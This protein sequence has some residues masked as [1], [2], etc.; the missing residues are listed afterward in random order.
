MRTLIVLTV[1][2]AGLA[3]LTGCG[4]LWWLAGGWLVALWL[5]AD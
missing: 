4:E 2:T 1:A 5:V 3:Q